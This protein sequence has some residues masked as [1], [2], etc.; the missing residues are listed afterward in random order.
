MSD[1]WDEASKWSGSIAT[2][3]AF[4]ITGW[5]GWIM[6]ARRTGEDEGSMRTQLLAHKELLAEHDREIDDLKS[7][8]A[9]GAAPSCL[10]HAR[11]LGE[12][13]KM[14]T[15]LREDF[16]TQKLEIARTLVTTEA[17]ARTEDRLRSD[18]LRVEATVTTAIGLAQEIIK[19]GL[20]ASRPRMLRPIQDEPEKQA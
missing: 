3:V 10:V 4:S 12:Q 2:L 7:Q 9:S 20:P 17:L 16:N 6:R 1:M 8:M 5:A 14:L 11:D 18:I 15:D 19:C 13:R